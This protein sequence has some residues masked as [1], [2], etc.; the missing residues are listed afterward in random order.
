[1]R[2]QD[3]LDELVL[4]CEQSTAERRVRVLKD[5]PGHDDTVYIMVAGHG[6]VD[7]NGAYILTYDSDPKDLAHSAIA[8][9]E[10][11]ALCPFISL[12]G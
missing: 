12:R 10:L 7:A 6:T 4:P 1:M 5:G 11:R 3:T 8:M 2:V 9:G